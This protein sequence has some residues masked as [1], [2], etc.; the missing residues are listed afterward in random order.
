MSLWKVNDQVSIRL[1]DEFYGNLLGGATIDGALRQTKL[2]YLENADELSADPKIW[3]PLVAYGSL[4]KVFSK[5]RS[6][7]VLYLGGAFILALLL[8][9]FNKLRKW[10]LKN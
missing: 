8:L 9:S 1:M 2:K 5:D 3:A 4:D 7:I 10:G 6:N